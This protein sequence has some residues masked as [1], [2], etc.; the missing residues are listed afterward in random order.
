ML[1]L[2]LFFLLI[3]TIFIDSQ[4]YCGDHK[5]HISGL[6]KFIDN[7]HSVEPGV[8]YRSGQLKPKSLAKYVKKYGIKTI[9]NLRGENKDCGWW[10]EEKRI[11]DELGVVHHSLSFCA[12]K[13]EK[14]REI[15]TLLDIYKNAPRPILIHCLSGADRT[16]EA[17]ALWVLEQQGKNK[18]EALKQ[19]SL[20]YRYLRLRRPQ[21]F[22]LVKYWNGFKN[23][24]FTEATS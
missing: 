4:T 18:K 3:Q 10:R 19:L 15:N 2:F 23:F 6:K 7:F 20:Y 17:A 5:I 16:G 11:A 14:K 21:K 24:K 13:L 8:C 12:K 22:F 1:S 9:I